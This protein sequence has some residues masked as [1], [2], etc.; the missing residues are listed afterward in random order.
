MRVAIIGAGVSGNVCAWLLHDRHQITLFETNSRP[1]GHT[2]TV[3]VTVFDDEYAVDT[4]FMVFNERTY[5]NFIA[6]LRRLGISGQPSDMSFS[7]R[8]GRTGLEYQGSSLNGLFAQ[9]R[10][11]VRPRF[12]R[13]LAEIFR[14]NQ[15]ATQLRESI[16]D[17][18]KLGVFLREQ[19]FSSDFVNAYLVP[20]TAAIWSAPAQRVLEMPAR[21]L[22]Q[23]CHNHGLLQIRDRPVWQTVPGG[24]RRYVKA[25]LKP[26]G[27][28]VRLNVAVEYVRRHDREV[29]LTTSDGQQQRFDVVVF[30]CHADQALRMLA[31]PTKLE[32]ETLN[33]F[34]YQSNLAVLHTDTRPLPRRRAAWASWNYFV[35]TDTT[36]PVSVTYD[37]NRLQSLGAPAPICVTLNDRTSLD[38]QKI[39]AEIEYQHPVFGAG[40]LAA[41][42]AQR[43]LNGQRRSF[44]CGAYW[45]YGFHEDGVV[46]ALTV[47]EQFGRSMEG[48]DEDLAVRFE[49]RYAAAT[50]PMS[51]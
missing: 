39:I 28:C 14:F 5:P 30:A 22:F 1:G 15:Q 4:G 18:Q 23:F 42:Q 12:Y 46:S 43:Q 40:T 44:Y 20:M 19:R 29:V 6:L 9:R 49:R 11:L 26:L 34:P 37:L 41:Q 24:A 48:W 27:A 38:S 25:L 50:A 16:D 3:D 47:C 21:F 10:N 51:E 13:M 36:Q 7:V 31:E 35:S 8:C 2:N 33:Q 32:T 45:R 17:Q